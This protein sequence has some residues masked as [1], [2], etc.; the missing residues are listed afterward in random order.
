MA[1]LPAELG[2]LYAQQLL[3]IAT[4]SLGMCGETTRG[5]GANM[6]RGR[7]LLVDDEPDILS[8]LAYLLVQEGFEVTTATNGSD[9]LRIAI[10]KEALD[11]VITDHAMPGT[12]GVALLV[13]LSELRPSV[14]GI[15]ISAYAAAISLGELPPGAALLRKPFRREV[16]LD[17]IAELMSRDMIRNQTIV[18]T[19]AAQ[20][21]VTE[22]QPSSR[23]PI[24]VSLSR[25]S[26]Y[27][28][29]KAGS[30]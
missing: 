18:P 15:V 21:T 14:A 10:N 6:V 26:P 8:G 24:G 12:T 27:E 20:A 28:A 25:P 17:K 11:I 4:C 9:A 5:K 3:A 1:S 13:E 7:I 29:W 19:D 23:L 2:N 16:L 22:L 30:V